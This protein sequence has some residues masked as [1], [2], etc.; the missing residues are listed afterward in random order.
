MTLLNQ[1]L[2]WILADSSSR[3]TGNPFDRHLTLSVYTAAG[4]HSHRLTLQQC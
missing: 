3:Y 4:L 2:V 1:R